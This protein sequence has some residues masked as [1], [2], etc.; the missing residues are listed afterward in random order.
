MLRCAAPLPADI[1]MTAR[2]LIEVTHLWR[3]D[4]GGAEP[5]REPVHIPR[6]AIAASAS[7]SQYVSGMQAG[8]SSPAPPAPEL[9]EAGAPLNDITSRHVTTV[10]HSTVQ[11]H[12]RMLFGVAEMHFHGPAMAT[13]ASAGGDSRGWEAPSEWPAP[14]DF[15]NIV[16]LA[17]MVRAGA[18]AA[19][20][21]A[22]V[23]AAAA[24]AAAVAAAA[25]AAAGPLAPPQARCRCG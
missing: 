19:A 14:L 24:A 16:V 1:D 10:E 22:A 6:S 21:A 18:S 15:R 20:A 5:S 23:A 8:A 3:P 2:A 4:D 9:V 17:P 7:A 25:A 12:S 11:M 13:V